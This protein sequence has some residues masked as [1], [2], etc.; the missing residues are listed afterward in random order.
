MGNQEKH[1]NQNAITDIKERLDVIIASKET[2]KKHQKQIQQIRAVLAEKLTPV[3]EKQ[4]NGDGIWDHKEL[5]AIRDLL[6]P[7]NEYF[8]NTRLSDKNYNAA[9]P[10]RSLYFRIKKLSKLQK[11]LV[12]HG[13]KMHAPLLPLYVRV[14]DRKFNVYPSQ[15]PV[16]TDDQQW[17]RKLWAGLMKTGYVGNI[18]NMGFGYDKINEYQGK[19]VTDAIRKS[20]TYQKALPKKNAI[21]I[22][23]QNDKEQKLLGQDGVFDQFYVFFQKP[24]KTLL[25]I[26]QT[27]SFPPSCDV[28]RY[29]KQFYGG[30]IDTINEIPH[31]KGQ[32]SFEPKN[33]Y[34]TTQSR[35]VT[36]D[37]PDPTHFVFEVSCGDSNLEKHPIHWGLNF[38]GLD[39]FLFNIVKFV[40][41]N[42]HP[43]RFFGPDDH[44]TTTYRLNRSFC[45]NQSLIHPT[46]KQFFR[47]D[48]L[49]LLSNIHYAKPAH[50]KKQPIK[51]IGAILM[52]K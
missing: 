37:T 44:K 47:N 9:W 48:Q 51:N 19:L 14:V 8:K 52:I 13:Q 21:Y 3:I 18:K 11:N 12:Q 20:S 10:V 26:D 34:H 7:V 28:D 4:L 24:Q 46:D 39:G 35:Q 41:N 31:I 17:M 30:V 36:L 5:G 43:L 27:F 40:E 22:Y 2:H 25:N 29:T 33:R 32:H 50:V 42:K 45:I 6:S 16:L 15:L 49:D 38:R 1:E 23:M